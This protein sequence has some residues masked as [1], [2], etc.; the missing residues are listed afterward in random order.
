MLNLRALSFTGLGR[1][2]ALIQGDEVLLAKREFGDTTGKGTGSLVGSDWQRL[3]RLVRGYAPVQHSFSEASLVA[4]GK[5][6]AP[7][8]G[9]HFRVFAGF[10]AA[11]SA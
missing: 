4:P 6:I 11:G 9:A 10:G 5:D 2:I 7:G 8:T 1:A 3:H